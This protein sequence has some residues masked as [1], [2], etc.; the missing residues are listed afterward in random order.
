MFQ[1]CGRLARSRTGMA[2]TSTPGRSAFAGLGGRAIAALISNSPAVRGLLIRRSGQDAI[3]PS[4]SC[5]WLHAEKTKRPQPLATRDEARYS[6][7]AGV[8]D[9]W[10]AVR[11]SHRK[12]CV[13]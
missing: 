11:A 9:R 1:H 10:Q 13:L 6:F 12:T 4:M 7:S 5:G 2:I 8:R 3:Q